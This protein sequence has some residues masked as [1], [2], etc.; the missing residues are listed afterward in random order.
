MKTRLYLD[1]RAGEEPYPLKLGISRKGKTAYIPLDVQL[2]TY[3]WDRERRQ[4]AD[5]PPRLWAGREAV[6]N[7][8]DRRRT[9]IETALMQLQADGALHRLSAIEIRDT[10]LEYLGRLET[11]PQLFVPFFRRH[12]ETI[13]NTRTRD[14]YG[15]TLKKIEQ[16]VSDAHTLT[17]DDIT[18]AWLM[19]LDKRLRASNPA[20]NTRAIHL[21]NI[22]AVFNRALD[23]ELTTN[24]PFR[25]YKIKSEE[26]I[27]RSLTLQQLHHYL[28]A[29]VDDITAPY[30]DIFLLMLYLLGINIG[31]LCCLRPADLRDGRIHYKRKK[32]GKIYSVKVERE[33]ME[34]I[35]R[36]RGKEYLL[37][38]CDRYGNYHDYLYHLDKRLK[39]V[40][41]EPP[42]C[43]ISTN[44]ARHT[45][46]TL[47][48]NELDTPIETV[49][50]AL[51]HSYGS[52]VTAVYINF[53]QRKVDAANRRLI[54][55]ITK[56]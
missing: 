19:M 12:L 47:M 27:K 45:A 3:Q 30:R 41:P 51:G 55:L 22:R 52:K 9:E 16:L 32:T 54:D 29:P 44:W 4:L 49:S 34:I 56:G 53:D 23:E 8:I 35:D 11:N 37:N 21:R 17:F 38:I 28:S 5:L 46:A 14:I 13:E 15:I 26:T 20:Q 18:P 10:T 43:Y 50:A 31:D 24:Y 7:Y 1:T 2:Y 39:M 42:Y 25:K 48:I 33:A 36:Y 6:R 40:L